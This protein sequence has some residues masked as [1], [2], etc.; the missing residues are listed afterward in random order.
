M[1]RVE[2]GGTKPLV[3]APLVVGTRDKTWRMNEFSG[4]GISRGADQ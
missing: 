2:T 3:F 4:P 1:V